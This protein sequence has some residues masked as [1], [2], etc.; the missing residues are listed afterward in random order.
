VSVTEFVGRERLVRT[1]KFVVVAFEKIP[2]DGVVAPGVCRLLSPQ[3][4]GTFGE[5]KPVP[6]TLSAF[7][8]VPLAVANPN[9][10]VD[11][12]PVKTAVDGVVAPIVELLIVPPVM[13]FVVTVQSGFVGEH[14]GSSV[15]P[16]E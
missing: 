16:G 8:F 5:T 7:N 3:V 12:A 6:L 1:E 11:V 15:W 2:V 9:Q 4:F 13:T 14:A 10:F